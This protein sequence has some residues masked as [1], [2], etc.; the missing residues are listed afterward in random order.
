MFDKS[1]LKDA[2]G[3]WRTQSLFWEIRNENYAPI[4]TL[5]D[6]DHEVDGVTYPSLKLIYMEF[7]DTTEYEFAMAVFGSW[8]AWQKI[9]N[10]QDIKA[11]V[12]DWRMEMEIKIR[13]K[14][15]K[16]LLKTAT[17]EGSK[18]T[19]AAKY[20]AEKGWEKT[21]GRPNKDEV[22][23]EKKIHAGMVDDISEDAKR[24]D[25]H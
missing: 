13:S 25:I 18:G 19:A 2:Q 14:A 24:L 10:N 1:K 5:K 15:I 3:R 8:K 9:S 20:I 22:E 4:Y 12:D 21:R 16:S 7:L 17:S 11:F 6:Y 23:R